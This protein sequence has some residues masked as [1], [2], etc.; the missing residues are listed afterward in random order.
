MATLLLV[1]ILL[2][3][4]DFRLADMPVTELKQKKP[5]PLGRTSVRLLG[6][7]TFALLACGQGFWRVSHAKESDLLDY[8]IH[9]IWI[10]D[11]NNVS[12][13]ILRCYF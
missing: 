2:F 7:S 11:Q 1:I 4:L 5:R 3:Y 6:N 13:H 12:S 10:T 8:D 9:K